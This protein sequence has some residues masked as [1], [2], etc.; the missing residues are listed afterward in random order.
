MPNQN[1]T[2]YIHVHDLAIFEKKSL[3]LLGIPPH[4]DPGA[5]HWVACIVSVSVRFSSK[6]RGTRVRDHAKNGASKRAGRGWGRKKKESFLPLPL[7]PLSFFGSHFISRAVKTENLPQSFFAPKTNGNACYAG[8]R[9]RLDKACIIIVS[10]SVA[11]SDRKRTVP[12]D[13]SQNL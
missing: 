8:Y 4:P 3:P 13:Q 12:C 5:P 6:E 9:L 2:D 7:P 10:L 11:F 1:Q